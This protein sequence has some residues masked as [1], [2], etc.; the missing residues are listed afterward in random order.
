M[1]DHLYQHLMNFICLPLSFEHFQSKD[2]E[3]C[4]FTWILFLETCG[5]TWIFRHLWIHMNFWKPVDLPEFVAFIQNLGLLQNHRIFVNCVIFA[6]IQKCSN[7]TKIH[8][9][10]TGGPISIIFSKICSS[11]SSPVQWY[12]PWGPQMKIGSTNFWII[13]TRSILNFYRWSQDETQE[14]NI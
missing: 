9:S 4:G 3:T 2:I 8:N 12:Q 11:R 6:K 14:A 1:L 13:T 5:F 10:G 7:F